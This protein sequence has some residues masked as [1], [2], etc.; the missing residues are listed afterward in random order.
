[1][2]IK[3]IKRILVFVALLVMVLLITGC[4]SDINL[5]ASMSGFSEP[6]ETLPVDD[7]GEES[8]DM[9]E[10]DY[11]NSEDFAEK[12]DDKELVELESDEEEEIEESKLNSTV[13]LTKTGSCYHIE[14]CRYLK[15]M[16]RSLTQ[17]E[18]IDEGYSACSYCIDSYLLPKYITGDN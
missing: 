15:S 2:H 8:A 10:Y 1:M 7:E 9:E 3:R 6:E 13:W 18:A 17:K 16:A 12:V 11:E 5:G 4:G 14:G